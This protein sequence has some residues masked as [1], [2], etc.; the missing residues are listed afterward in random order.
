MNSVV[1]GA[2]KTTAVAPWSSASKAIDSTR[3]PAVVP[4]PTPT[5]T[6]LCATE[7]I[8]WVIWIV[9]VNG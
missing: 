7:I 6:G 2:F 8:A 3:L 1:V 4:P 5:K 9:G